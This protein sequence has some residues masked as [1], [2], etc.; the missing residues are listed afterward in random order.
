M[1]EGDVHQGHEEDDNTF[2]VTPS[3]EYA[4][5]SDDLYY[6]KTYPLLFPFGRGG[7]RDPARVKPL[8]SLHLTQLRLADCTRAFGKNTAFMF[9]AFTKHSLE[10][11][12][13]R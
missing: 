9:D 11:A 6:E 12:S 2:I 4:S 5:N 10:E 8:S 7:N 3:N 13:G 1:L